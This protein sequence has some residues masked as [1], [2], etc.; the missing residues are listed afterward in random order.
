MEITKL[1]LTQGVNSRKAVKLFLSTT[2]R[3]ID[4]HEV[5]STNPLPRHQ[6]ELSGQVHAPAALP[7]GK[8]A[9]TI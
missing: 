1:Y 4:G 3:H 2:Q 8:N 7:L 5:S 9:G 6:L